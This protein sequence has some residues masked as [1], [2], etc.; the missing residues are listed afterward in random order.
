M[1]GAQKG[2]SYS[3]HCRTKADQPFPNALSLVFL[4]SASI[5]IAVT[6]VCWTSVDN[7]S[8]SDHGLLVL[9]VKSFMFSSC[10]G[11]LIHEVNIS[12]H[13][14]TSINPT[15]FSYDHLWRTPPPTKFSL[16]S[17][18]VLRTMP[19]PPTLA[20]REAFAGWQTANGEPEAFN[21]MMVR[22]RSLASRTSML[23]SDKQ[24]T[25]PKGMT[26]SKMQLWRFAAC[27][28]QRTIDLDDVEVSTQPR[29]P[30]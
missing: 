9:A 25:I 13:F 14:F 27:Q 23:T 4:T 15:S 21:D 1:I 30:P 17:R 5:S 26:R 19:S 22:A 8:T 29:L 2:F 10:F 20:P 18:R 28:S 3:W 12:L 16:Q 7:R 6:H 24:R 11:L